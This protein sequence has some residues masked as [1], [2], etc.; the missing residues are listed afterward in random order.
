MDKYIIEV[1]WEV[2]TN[3]YLHRFLHLVE[4]FLTGGHG[5]KMETRFYIRNMQRTGE[6]ILFCGRKREKGGERVRVVG[7]MTP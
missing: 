7:K 5:L 4:N 6:A 1:T 2:I 3:R